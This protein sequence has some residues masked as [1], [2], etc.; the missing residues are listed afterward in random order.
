MESPSDPWKWTTDDVVEQLCLPNM[1]LEARPTSHLPNSAMLEQILRSNEIDGPTL[2]VDVDQ[3]FLKEQGI[4]K[5]GEISALR[6]IITVLRRRSL[7]YQ[8]HVAVDQRASDASIYSGAETPATSLSRIPH[9]YYTPTPFAMSENAL[10]R[11]ASTEPMQKLT[12]Q[13][14]AN[15]DQMQV[16]LPTTNTRAHE[17]YVED[18]NGR[19]R[20]KLNLQAAA[21]PEPAKT[22]HAP[23]KKSAV[24]AL[25][26]LP[27]RVELTGC[28]INDRFLSS[29][30]LLVD[31]VF[32][33]QEGDRVVNSDVD[34]E[35]ALEDSGLKLVGPEFGFHEH[36]DHGTIQQYVYKQMLHYLQNG[37]EPVEV[38]WKGKNAPAVFPYRSK[39]AS[40][41]G[42]RS[43]LLL[44]PQESSSS[45]KAIRLKQDDLDLVQEVQHRA[46][47]P[48][49]F[50]TLQRWKTEDHDILPPYGE[51][52]DDELSSSFNAEL[53]A[54]ECEDQ[55]AAANCRLLTRDQ[56]SNT[57]DTAIQ[58]FIHD[59]SERKLPLREDK[60]LRLWRRGKSIS[61]RME[62]A[63]G[64]DEEVKRLSK[65]LD[66]LVADTSA[67]QWSKVTNLRHQCAALEETVTSRE[68][69]RFKARIWRQKEAPAYVVTAPHVRV[70]KTRAH[71]L[72]S[73]D[74]E[75]I[76]LSSDDDDEHRTSDQL[77]DFMEDDTITTK[78]SK[79][80][81][82][83]AA[84]EEDVNMNNFSEFAS[85]VEDAFENAQLPTPGTDEPKGKCPK[86]ADIVDLTL[87]SSSDSEPSPSTKRTVNKLEKSKSNPS[88][89][90]IPVHQDIGPEEEPDDNILRRQFSDLEA[91]QDRHRL[92]IKLLRMM[93]AEE[94]GDLRD[95]VLG[96]FDNV[97]GSKGGKAFRDAVHLATRAIRD[98]GDRLLGYS[99]ADSDT[100]FHAAHLFACW[101]YCTSKYFCGKPLQQKEGEELFEH[102]KDNKKDLRAFSNLVIRQLRKHQQP[103]Q[104]ST[105]THLNAEEVPISIES[106]SDQ[107][108][109]DLC[110]DVKED[111]SSQVSDD[112]EE[113]KELSDPASDVEGENELSD[114]ASEES[115]PVQRSPRKKRKRAVIENQAAKERR[116]RARMNLESQQQRTR[117]TL[118]SSGLMESS[119]LIT[120]NPG[121]SSSPDPVSLSPK[122]IA[123]NLG[124]SDKHEPIYLN[125]HIASRIHS[126]QVEGIQF[127]WREI[128]ATDM[129]ETDRQGA[130]LSHTMGLGKTMQT[131]SLLVTIAEAAAEPKTQPQIPPSLRKSR[132]LILCPSSL[133][134][135]WIDE[136]NKWLPANAAPLVGE[137]FP[138][139]SDCSY[140]A[141]LRKIAEWSENGGVLLISYDLFR[142]FVKNSLGKSPLSDELYEKVLA[143]LTDNPHIV[144]ADE[145]HKLKN[146]KS[147]IGQAASKFKTSSR[148][149]LTGSPLSNNLNEYF[150]MIDWIAPGYLGSATEFRANYEEPIREGGYVD[151]DAA[152]RRK[153]RKKLKILE[154]V[155]EPKIHRR[156][157]TVLRG[158]LQP[159]TE[160]V[161]FVPLTNIQKELYSVYVEALGGQDSVSAARIFDWLNTLGLITSHPKAFE[162]KLRERKAQ[163]EKK[164]NVCKL[165]IPC[166]PKTN[167]VVQEKP[168]TPNVTTPQ[169]SDGLVDSAQD[170]DQDITGFGLSLSMIREQG[171]ILENVKNLSHKDHSIRTLLLRQILKKSKE[172]GD[173]VLVFSQS[174]PTLDF[175]QEK[176]RKWHTRFVRLDGKTKMSGRTA[177]VKAFNQ[178]TID[179]FLISTR[180]GGLGFNLPAANRVIIF[181]FSFNPQWEEQAI[182]RAYR[183]G[184]EKRVYVY[185]FIAGGT[186]EEKLFNQAVFKTQLAFKVVEKKDT[187]NFAQRQME[188]LFK[189]KKVK[190]ESLD[191][192]QGK[193]PLLDE[194]LTSTDLQEDDDGRYMIRRIIAAETLQD[195]ADEVLTAEDQQE[196]QQE[197]E[198]E[199]LR[200]ENPAAYW[201][202]HGNVYEKRTYAQPLNPTSQ[203]SDT[204][205]GQWSSRNPQTPAAPRAPS[206]KFLATTDGRVWP[207]TQLLHDYR[208]HGSTASTPGHLNLSSTQPVSQGR[209]VSIPLWGSSPM[210]SPW[211]SWPYGHF[212][213]IS[214]SKA[215]PWQTTK[216]L[217]EDD[218]ARQMDELRKRLQQP[219]SAVTT[220]STDRDVQIGREQRSEVDNQSSHPQAQSRQEAPE[221]VVRL[222]IPTLHQNG[223]GID[224]T[225]DTPDG[226]RSNSAHRPSPLVVPQQLNSPRGHSMSARSD[227]SQSLP[228]IED[229]L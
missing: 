203:Y 16:H 226:H 215:D 204:L 109:S 94:Y 191:E 155:T 64:A 229:L 14:D 37:T 18:Q 113:K 164:A 193:D 33:G 101:Y 50:D 12:T 103:I 177:L 120:V 13:A 105:S 15:D 43:L 142:N 36:T 54:D 141:R 138:I 62:L 162:T 82:I 212:P 89:A 65:R 143:Q 48:E 116:E 166:S 170:N 118:M 185:R 139:E 122:L 83:D 93:P 135:N 175:L 51:S 35:I 181:D 1:L 125:S 144:I 220:K 161:L 31:I 2:L 63:S 4:T 136:F 68:E 146:P 47:D 168:E 6:Y 32:F 79:A 176:L 41:S 69:Q 119:G 205:G 70:R 100:V 182:G 222:Q 5:L 107:P 133:I 88:S 145:A 192:H 206:A 55:D 97:H 106:S 200:K 130:L 169:D 87:L 96:L 9:E 71:T 99:R 52:D 40:S 104:A 23:N 186:F 214:S 114:K 90:E 21:Q 171:K 172:L 147:G 25:K 20:R 124:K 80:W 160:F 157:V 56:V 207:A 219:N 123:I 91:K 111:L 140:A 217:S 173:G 66:K 188:Y 24:G 30:K 153:A 17:T 115:K 228:A 108:L 209:N 152:E 110:D 58:E 201:Q 165:S 197:I 112:I 42:S 137:L 216:I 223:A 196:I 178:G 72:H 46:L 8:T 151:S 34:A 129:K 183:I 39:L 74:E 198:N 158:T 189:P 49:D 27:S 60:A 194:I 154:Q 78:R 44:E 227:R 84:I 202:K 187:K 92:I 38:K 28:D 57:I 11:P 117:L 29:S 190:Q 210:H 199:R 174:I 195:P 22:Q 75:G 45:F 132:T 127:L 221:Q 53:D 26:P 7:G 3:A 59:W 179:V 131:I 211:L 218:R 225:M 167:D 159:K 156:D 184:Q 85:E 180:A 67:L 224:R 128:V 121:K 86:P 77:G 149:A 10:K 61:A 102:I 134:A 19:K 163:L 98:G 81:A 213:E 76:V 208:T 95:Y 150:A 126:H 148:I 73:S